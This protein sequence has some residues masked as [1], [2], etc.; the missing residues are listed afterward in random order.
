MPMTGRTIHCVYS[1][2]LIPDYPFDQVFGPLD[3][4]VGT[5]WPPGLASRAVTKIITFRLMCFPTLQRTRTAHEAYPPERGVRASVLC[6]SSRIRRASM[7]LAR[8]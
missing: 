3:S 2:S 8:G 1:K 5:Y 4:F 7:T 6:T